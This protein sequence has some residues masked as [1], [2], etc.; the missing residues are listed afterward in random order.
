[1]STEA[2]P[3]THVDEVTVVDLSDS[4]T[5]TGTSDSP[6]LKHPAIPK[7]LI[8]ERKGWRWAVQNFTPAWF[9]SNMGTGIVATLLYTFSNMYPPNRTVFFSLS[10]AF[11]IINVVLFCLYFAIS[12]L[13]YSLYPAT[14]K[15][16]FHHPL[17]SLFIGTVPMGFAGIIN[18]FTLACVSRW[19]GASVQVA[20]GLWFIDSILSLACCFGIPFLMMT[21]HTHRHETM[22]AVWFL[23]IV[24]P[25]V[26][27]ATGALVA[28]ALTNPQHALWT[29][30][31]SYILWGTSVPLSFIAMTIYFY[32][33]AVHNLPAHSATVSVFLPI[34]SMGLGGFAI[35]KLGRVAMEVFPQTGTLHPN[36]GEI[37]HV[38]GFGFALIMWGFGLV[39]LVF[40]IC[41][42]VNRRR[43]PFNI[44][45]WGFT[46]PV[47]VFAT[48]TLLFGEEMPST[49]F[50]V[51]G[52]ILSVCVML[53]WIVVAYKTVKDVLFRRALF[54]SPSL[55]EFEKECEMKEEEG[56]KEQQD[57]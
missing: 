6:D 9:A 56:E 14:W 12:V 23:P 55:R 18:M 40:A 5:E 13:R 16:T 53:I 36:G 4:S 35:L 33:L 47:G 15:L 49:F 21:K 41:S 1:M 39:W 38:I 50:R 22:T 46:F 19:G 57:V 10:M 7:W 54:D 32:R 28:D 37:L 30:T 34:G 20:W 29:I 8:R 51:M 24:S 11:F 43:F 26:A 2:E 52:T 45:W 48:A 42:I 44:G 25:I 27:S 17:E 31:I 3:C